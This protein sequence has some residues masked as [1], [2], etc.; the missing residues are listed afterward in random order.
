MQVPIRTL[1]NAEAGTADLPDALF[2]ATPRADILARVVHWQLSKRRAG[3]HKVKGMSEVQGTTKKPY[4]QKGTGNA[5]QGSLRA[6]QYRHGGVVHGPVV[7]S[8]EYSLNKKVRRLGLI[9]ALSQKQAEGKLVVLD[10]AT[11]ADGS[12]TKD[13]ARRVKAL[14]W[15]SALIVDGV[16]DPGFLR[17]SRNL[18]EIDVLPTIGANVYDI[19]R[20]DVLA[21]T[22][23]G[24]A[25]LTAR[26][27]TRAGGAATAPAEGD[28]A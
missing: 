2:A 16:V 7:R 12:K 1:D 28:A 19:L 13:L 8:H 9:S 25:G 10:A 14:G 20:H 15:T 17:A 21:I 6:P 22:A 26:L 3:T 11:A 5:R 23:A 18:P 4:R 27:T 24:L